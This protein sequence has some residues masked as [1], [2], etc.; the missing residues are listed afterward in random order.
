MMMPVMRG[1]PK[2]AFLKG[3]AP[4]PRHDELKDPARP[5]RSMREIPMIPGRNSKHPDKVEAH[6]K[7]KRDRIHAGPNDRKARDME[8]H[9][10]DAMKDVRQPVGQ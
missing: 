8:R 7:R 9:E 5:V 6:A 1:P 2:R 3:A 4:K 10:G